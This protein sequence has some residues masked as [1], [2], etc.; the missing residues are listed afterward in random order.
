MWINKYKTNPDLIFHVVPSLLTITDAVLTKQSVLICSNMLVSKLLVNSQVFPL[1]SVP[2][3]SSVVGSFE[4][5]IVL[6][7]V[8]LSGCYCCVYIHCTLKWKTT[9]CIFGKTKRNHFTIQ[10][11]PEFSLLAESVLHFAA[12]LDAEILD[13]WVYT[14]YAWL[15][16]QSPACSPVLIAHSSPSPFF[17]S[18]GGS[19]T[20]QHQL[21]FIPLVSFWF[22][23]ALTARQTG[24]SLVTPKYCCRGKS[25]DRNFLKLVNELFTLSFHLSF[26]LLGAWNI[27]LLSPVL[28]KA[29][30]KIMDKVWAVWLYYWKGSI[31]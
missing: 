19:C 8:M 27:V 14:L 6:T 10:P 12:Y 31:W 22:L 3:N 29:I 16:L 15:L 26:P 13:S 23:L 4:F 30:M 17:P 18:L 25:S 28:R 9:C 5:I 2:Y 1:S 21:V 24:L 7:E 11:C 20:S